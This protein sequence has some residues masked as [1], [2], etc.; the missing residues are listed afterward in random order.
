VD[1]DELRRYRRDF[2]WTTAIVDDDVAILILQY[3]A[4]ATP[5]DPI[6]RALSA[7]GWM[8]FHEMRRVPDTLV[9]GGDHMEADWIRSGDPDTYEDLSDMTNWINAALGRGEI[10]VACAPGL[11]DRCERAGHLVFDG[12]LTALA[13]VIRSRTATL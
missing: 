3:V 2:Y 5:G 10:V 6:M 11:V 9:I 7:V 8:P 4:A 13:P 12:A 1:L